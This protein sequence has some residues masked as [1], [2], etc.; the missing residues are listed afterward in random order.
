[1]NPRKDENGDDMTIEVTPRAAKV[2]ESLFLPI[3][4]TGK[5]DGG[6]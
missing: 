4:I 5:T 1:M 6:M 3:S 2:R